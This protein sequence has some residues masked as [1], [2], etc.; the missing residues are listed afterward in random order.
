[1][2]FRAEQTRPRRLSPGRRSLSRAHLFHL[3]QSAEFGASDGGVFDRVVGREEFSVGAGGADFEGTMAAWVD[4]ATL[5]VAPS[6]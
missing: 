4:D 3:G 5:V 2:Y 1:M 6:D